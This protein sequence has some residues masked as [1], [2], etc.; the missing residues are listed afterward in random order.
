MVDWTLHL[1]TNKWCK[2]FL[3][4]KFKRNLFTGPWSA[5][6][7]LLWTTNQQLRLITFQE[8]NNL[9]TDSLTWRGEKDVMEKHISQK[10]GRKQKKYRIIR[11]LHF[12]FFFLKLTKPKTYIFVHSF[13]DS[14]SLL[15]QDCCCCDDPA[16]FLYS[17]K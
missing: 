8:I 3:F 16:F 5:T 13:A 2:W 10:H 4:F 11:Q 12:S 15:Y 9:T 1:L 6:G 7:G 14:S 17:I